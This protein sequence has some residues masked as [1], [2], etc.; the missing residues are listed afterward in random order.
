MKVILTAKSGDRNYCQITIDGFDFT[1]PHQGITKES[2]IDK[3]QSIQKVL[4]CN[5][6]NVDWLTVYTD[7]ELGISLK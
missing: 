4:L 1:I 7:K 2:L 6:T 5:F 3:A